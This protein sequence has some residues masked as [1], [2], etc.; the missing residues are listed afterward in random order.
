M[1]RIVVAKVMVTTE[2]VV[3]VVLATTATVVA[4][5]AKARWW[6]QQPRSC[7]YKQK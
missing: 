6:R 1:V 2:T 4:V 3:S 5:S 7:N